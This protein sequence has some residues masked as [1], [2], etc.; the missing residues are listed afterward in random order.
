MSI[1][2]K[3][4]TKVLEKISNMCKKNVNYTNEVIISSYKDFKELL[5]EDILK[6]GNLKL[7]KNIARFSLPEIVTCSCNCLGCYAK[8][9]LFNNVK[10]SRLKRLFLIEHA[11]QDTILLNF[12]KIKLNYE[13]K[14]HEFKC[15]LHRKKPIMRWHD[16]GDIYSIEYFNFI[17]DIAFENPF[18]HFYTYTK[19]MHVWLLYKKLQKENKIPKNFN[20]VC[21]YI[22]NHVN[23]FDFIHDF[24]NE[25]NSLKNIV[26]K[27]RKDKIKIFLCNYYFDKMPIGYQIKLY[28]FIKKNKDVIKMYK[29]HAT[30]GKC[31]KCCDYEHVIF[32][33]H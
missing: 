5:N 19:N 1:L 4:N 17:L 29:N 9:R 21:S 32:I 16:S 13:L 20:I 15:N 26:K 6:F 11:L 27:A 31:S 30:C 10:K 12:L 2:F 33:K 24:K 7:A 25:F 28:N 18:I 8:K 23:F 22:Y 3:K 14:I